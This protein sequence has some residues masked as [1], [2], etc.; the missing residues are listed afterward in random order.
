MIDK[1]LKSG[2]FPP[3][4]L[5]FGEEDLLVQ[6]EAQRLYNAA[7]AQD[8]TGMN[9]EIVD[10]DGMTL[11]AILGIA[12]SFPMMSDRRVLWVRRFE[13]VCVELMRGYSTQAPFAKSV[14]KGYFCA[15]NL[16]LPPSL[17]F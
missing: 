1:I 2:A 17:L 11:D 12:R 7:S 10:G 5:L 14:L 16:R 13:A 6:E 8:A 9:C 3:V 15:A 4:M